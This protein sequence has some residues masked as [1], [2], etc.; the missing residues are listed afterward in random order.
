MSRSQI[1]MIVAVVLMGSLFI[2]PMWKITLKAPQYPD[3][4]TMHIYINK[5]GGKTPGTLQ[6][7]NILNHYIGMKPIH[8]DS[9]P[10][11]K[12][13]PPIVIFFMIYGIVTVFVNRR[14]LYWTWAL[15]LTIMLALGLYD[16]YLWEYDYGH[17]LDPNAP[18]KFEGESFQP[19]LIGVKHIINFTAISLPGLAGYM[20]MISTFLGYGAA[21]TYPVNSKLQKP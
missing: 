8:P 3:G 20:V 13:M 7:V 18:M 9:I 14:W 5:I 12:L 4:V 15:S 17:S 21:S 16:F 1:M 19:P 6:N 11:L 10:E 2:W